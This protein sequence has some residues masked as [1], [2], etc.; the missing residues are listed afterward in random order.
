MVLLK[1]RLYYTIN[2]Y[3]I[4][5]DAHSFRPHLM[6]S[7]PMRLQT[8]LVSIHRQRWFNPVSSGSL[9]RRCAV[10]LAQYLLLGF[11]KRQRVL[12]LGCR[13]NGKGYD[14]CDMEGELEADSVRRSRNGRSTSAT[15]LC[16]VRSRRKNGGL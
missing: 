2:A 4:R 1:A 3:S 14:G 10:S 15:K 5:I 8:G 6:R 7:A 9:H 16:Y 12:E 11:A 13:L